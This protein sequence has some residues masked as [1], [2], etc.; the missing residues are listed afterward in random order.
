MI[1]ASPTKE[2]FIYMLVKDI[3]LKRAIIDLVD[4]CLDGAKRI[5][6]NSDYA[7]LHV[8]VEVGEDSFRVSDNC[9]GIPVSLARDY[10]FRF[11]RPSGMPST[12]HSIGQFGVGM[13][14]ALFKLG[15]RF[16][17]ESQ[18]ANS[19]FV[20]DEDVEQWTSKREWEF[21]F[22]EVDEDLA[23]IPSEQQGTT[24]T[25]TKLHATVAEQFK[26][27]NFISRLRSEIEEAHRDC[28]SKG[29]AITLNG[30]PLDMRPLQLLHSG[31]LK[32]ARREISFGKGKQKVD[33]QLFAGVSDSD[34]E[35]AGW[36]MFCNGRLVLGMDQSMTTG[37]GEGSGR[38]IPKFHNQFARFRGYAFFDADD[39]GLLPWNTTKTGV[40]ADS[41]IF[42]GIRLEML[43]MMRPV[44]DFLNRLDA[45]KDAKEE[46]DPKPL[47]AAVE[48]AS[49]AE[50]TEVSTATT[51][52][53]PK[54]SPKAPTPGPRTGRIQYSKPVSEIRRIQKELGVTTYKDVGERT[55]EYFLRAECEEE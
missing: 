35:A 40:D 54:P 16:I 42:R 43:Q 48:A 5:R 32:P 6:S 53:A 45:E 14:R 30:L 3:E 24:I 52:V 10:A 12:K 1:D 8:R 46:T 13:K 2:F 29:L 7:D 19:R 18:T 25:V 11:G 39:A 17:V 41:A 47:Q 21:R 22:A 38:V 37:W 20:V 31:Q 49:L 26:L 33:V 4:N 36:Y 9:G 55:F 44:I 23:G 15:A 50:Y 27:D 51:F 34:P 28:V